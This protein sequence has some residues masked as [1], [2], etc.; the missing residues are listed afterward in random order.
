MK[1]NILL[2]LQDKEDIKSL[3]NLKIQNLTLLLKK[4]LSNM[5]NI[6]YENEAINDGK[7]LNI[8]QE[9]INKLSEKDHLSGDWILLSIKK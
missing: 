8:N 3:F 4:Y 6:D 7:I 5:D 1:L 2:Q 9:I